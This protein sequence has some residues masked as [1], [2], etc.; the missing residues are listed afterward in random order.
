MSNL[1][2]IALRFDINSKS[3]KEF[4]ESLH[5]LRKKEQLKP[6]EIKNAIRKLLK[7][8]KPISNSISDNLST[9]VEISEN[10]I[11]IILQ[12]RHERDWPKY[13]KNIKNLSDKLSS[14]KAPLTEED[15]KLLEDIADALDAECEYL[16]QRLSERK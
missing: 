15:F 10:N 2:V 9:S 14:G 3:L 6:N 1:G 7:I 12:E 11:V 5:I 4:D 16:F 8:V 13:R